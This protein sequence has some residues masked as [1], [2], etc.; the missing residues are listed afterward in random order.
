MVSDAQD[1]KVVDHTCTALSRIAESYARHPER[2]DMLCN[3]GLITNAVQ[4]VR[5]MLSFPAA[6]IHWTPDTSAAFVR[7]VALSG[8]GIPEPGDSVLTARPLSVP[9]LSANWK[10]AMIHWSYDYFPEWRFGKDA[11]LCL[12]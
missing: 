10:T 5:Y 12:I 4:L 7:F 8:R 11:I 2:L 3:H 1:A 6:T 9:F